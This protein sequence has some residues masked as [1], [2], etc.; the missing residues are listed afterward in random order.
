MGSIDQWVLLAPHEVI[1][2]TASEQLAFWQALEETPHLTES[3]RRLGAII[4]GEDDLPCGA[5]ST[6]DCP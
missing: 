4:R 2:L 5:P 6:E 3:Q 1:R